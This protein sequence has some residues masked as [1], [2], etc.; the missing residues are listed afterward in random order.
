MLLRKA[1]AA[2]T[3][4]ETVPLAP[5]HVNHFWP[6]RKALG[7][8]NVVHIGVDVPDWRPGQQNRRSDRVLPFRQH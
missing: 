3:P 7:E 5:R 6:D 4:N 2:L 1:F 8:L